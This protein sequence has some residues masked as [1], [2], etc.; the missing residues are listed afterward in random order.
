MVRGEGRT[1]ER[2]PSPESWRRTFIMSM[3]WMAV[4]AV[5]PARPPLRKGRRRRTVGFWRR[6]GAEVVEGW[7][8]EVVG[9]GFD[10]F[11]GEG[12]RGEVVLWEEE[13]VSE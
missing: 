11:V 1:V 6:V 2:A 8:A 9:G 13:R 4:V 3:G 7:A 12:A 10:I 5:M